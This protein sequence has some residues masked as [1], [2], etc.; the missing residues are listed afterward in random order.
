M[1]LLNLRLARP[2]LV[3]DINGVA[4]L[5]YIDADDGAL[6]IGA[7]DAPGGPRALRARRSALAAA[8]QGGEAAW[9]IR[10][11]GARGTVGGSVAHAD[12]AAELP[13]ALIALGARFHLRS[14]VWRA[15][16]W[17]RP[18]SSAARSTT[19]REPDELLV[20]IEVPEQPDGRG[21]RASRST[22]ARTATS[23]RPARRPWWR[24]A[25]AGIALLGAGPAP[26]R[27]RGRRASAVRTARRRT[28][29]RRWRRRAW[30]AST[31][32]RCARSWRGARSRRRSR[33]DQRGDQ[34]ASSTRG[35]SSRARSCPTSS[36]TAPG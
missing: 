11:S 32:G 21:Q 36:A 16:R 28:R 9:A 15:R 5:D 20:E 23:R 19:A 22:R 12:P 13:A 33:E 17:R 30:R 31:G 7:H 6:R 10:R 27:R 35:M 14:A 29:P 25:H 24:Q 4:E 1:P 18:S 34:R 3:V 2:E 8:A 26:V